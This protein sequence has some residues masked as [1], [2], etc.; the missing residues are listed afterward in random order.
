MDA[1]MTDPRTGLAKER[2]S[3]AKF[4]TQLALDRTTLAWIRT[5]LTMA[6]FGF[7]MWSAN[8]L[9]LHADVFPAETM[10]SAMGTTLM[11]ASLGG[12]GFTFVVGQIVD[13][14]GYAPAFWAVGSLAPIACLALFFW[15]GP[16]TRIRDAEATEDLARRP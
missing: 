7:G 5:A 12:A 1:Q 2:T 15:L 13:Q 6:T 4:R 9:A 14:V 10:G 11:A 8:I 3:F 16:V